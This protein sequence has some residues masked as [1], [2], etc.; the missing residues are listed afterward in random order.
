MKVKARKGMSP[1]AFTSDKIYE[2]LAVEKG[3]YRVMTDIG[4]DYIFPPE[5]FELVEDD[6]DL[7]T[8]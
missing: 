6:S 5:C 3:W 1:I 4:E 8:A 7:V 2:V